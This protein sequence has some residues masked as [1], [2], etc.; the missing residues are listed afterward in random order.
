MV[1]GSIFSDVFVLAG[2]RDQE[3]TQ[4]GHRQLYRARQN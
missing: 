4:A 1:T 3:R 2:V